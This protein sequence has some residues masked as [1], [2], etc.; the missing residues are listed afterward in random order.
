[1]Q[2]GV[3]AGSGV[4]G[5]LM[6]ETGSADNKRVAVDL[7]S[8]TEAGSGAPASEAARCRCSRSVVNAAST[9]H[10]IFCSGYTRIP[11]PLPTHILVLMPIPSPP[12]VI[13]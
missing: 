1:M 5:A 4:P 7:R 3:A 9:D 6:V 11:T 2:P 10:A 12:F 8:A 13:G